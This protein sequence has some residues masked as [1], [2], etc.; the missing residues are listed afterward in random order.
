MGKLKSPV[1]DHHKFKSKGEY[2]PTD[3]ASYVNDRTTGNKSRIIYQKPQTTNEDLNN[4][5]LRKLATKHK[6]E[7]NTFIHQTKQK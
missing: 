7:V 5:K 1:F 6:K 3:I 2:I 4:D